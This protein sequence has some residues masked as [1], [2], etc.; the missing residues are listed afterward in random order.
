MHG[1]QSELQRQLELGALLIAA[2][3]DSPAQVAHER[4]GRCR[5]SGEGVQVKRGLRLI[6][7]L[8]R[9]Q[10]QARRGQRLHVDLARRVSR[11]PQHC[12]QAQPVRPV[13]GRRL[14]D[15]IAQGPLD[16]R[17]GGR[18]VAVDWR[19]RV[20]AV[21]HLHKLNMRRGP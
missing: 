11:V 10:L 7:E 21:A 16:I 15:R 20:G 12:A 14:A 13:L 9:R 1:P 19:L 17:A 3:I 8:E 6:S 18:A 5:L 2:F 4:P